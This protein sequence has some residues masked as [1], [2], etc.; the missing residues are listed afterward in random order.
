MPHRGRL[1]LLTD[2][3]RMDPALLFHKLMGRSELPPGVR[4]C[5]DVI[6]HLSTSVDLDYEAGRPLHVSL[7]HN[8]SHL[9]AVNPVAMG[10][11]RGKQMYLYEVGE[12][13]TVGWMR[14][15][16]NSADVVPP[17]ARTFLNRIRR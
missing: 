10:K 3:L 1:N 14:A 6:S 5:G 17:R 2:L 16:A 11:A 9:E 15:A 12:A 13:S 7:V 4:G 8:P